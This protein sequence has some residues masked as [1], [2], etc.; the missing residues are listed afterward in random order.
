MPH[1][2]RAVKKPYSSPSFVV[3]DA[4]AAKAKLKADGNP[5]DAMTLKMLSS[6]DDQLNRLKPK[7]HS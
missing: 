6:I 5:K 4:G 2:P 3:L 7:S 1:G